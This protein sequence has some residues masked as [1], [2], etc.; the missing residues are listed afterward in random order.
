MLNI[1]YKGS[2]I[3]SIIV[4]IL[5]SLYIGKSAI[6]HNPTEIY[7]KFINQTECHV[8]WKNLLPL[9]L[10]W[11]IIIFTPLFVI[12]FTVRAIYRKLTNK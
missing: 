12:S 2:V 11:F 8:V 10:T 3:F 6:D 1:T 5:F 7:C 9:L 4:A